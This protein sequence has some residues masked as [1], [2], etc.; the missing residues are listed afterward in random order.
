MYFLLLTLLM[1]IG[2]GTAP[3]K[4]VFR[5]LWSWA[6]FMLFAPGVIGF[7]LQYALLVPQLLATKRF[8]A[9]GVLAV[10]GA[11]VASVVCVVIIALVAVTSHYSNFQINVFS[12]P[13][14]TLGLIALLASLALIH[15][16]IATVIRGFISWYDD[17]A[18]STRPI[19][20]D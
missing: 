7:Y 8:V 10:A 1:R 17:I 20:C 2:V 4:N 9:F 19:G 3:S 11:L 15:M 16:I 6:G 18:V 14:S 12:S 5:T 13:Q